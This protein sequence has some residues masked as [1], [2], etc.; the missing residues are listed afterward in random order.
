MVLAQP[1]LSQ[2]TLCQWHSCR[3][4]PGQGHSSGQVH[5][6]AG[7]E[8]AGSGTARAHLLQPAESLWPAGWG[9]LDTQP[10]HPCTGCLQLW[11]PIRPPL[12]QLGQSQA[13]TFWADEI[14]AGGSRGTGERNEM[15]DFMY[16]ISIPWAHRMWKCFVLSCI[17]MSKW[18]RSNE[19][20]SDCRF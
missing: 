6:T 18:N 15:G 5:C 13:S 9:G 4:A 7:E 3:T 11:L 2:L 14:T 16:C 8:E 10:L 19:D 12:L 20:V 17:A 1:H